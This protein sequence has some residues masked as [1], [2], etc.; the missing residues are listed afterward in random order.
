MLEY[1]HEHDELF[2][3]IANIHYYVIWY[4]IEGH[5]TLKSFMCF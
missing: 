5:L 2:D 1:I 3:I 4:N